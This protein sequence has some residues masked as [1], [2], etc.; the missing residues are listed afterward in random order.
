MHMTKD[1]PSVLEDSPSDQPLHIRLMIKR[2]DY[3]GKEYY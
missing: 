3:L 1:D 2:M